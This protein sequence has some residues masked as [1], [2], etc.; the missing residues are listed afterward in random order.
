MQKNWALQAGFWITAV[1]LFLFCAYYFWQGDSDRA[2]NLFITLVG[3]ILGGFAQ[4]LFQGN[5]NQSVSFVSSSGIF[6]NKNFQKQYFTLLGYQNRD[7]DIKGLSTQTALTLE[8][9]Q[10]FVELKLQP[11]AAHKA[12][13]NP[14]NNIPGKMR[15]DS[16]PIWQFFAVLSE[17]EKRKNA[18]IVIVGPPGSGKTTLLRHITLSLVSSSQHKELKKIKFKKIPVLFYLREHVGLILEN[19]GLLLPELI[20]STITK[21]DLTVPSNWFNTRMKN[22]ECMIMLDGLDEVAEIQSRRQIVSWL[23]KQMW[24]YPNNTFMIT[25]RPHGYRENP[26]KGVSVL[27][28]MPFNRSQ[29]DNFVFNWYLANEIKSHAVDDVGVRMTAKSGASDLLTRL[30]KNAALMELAVNPLLLTMIATVHRY[31]S[32]L[33]GRRV[34]LYKEICEVFLGKRQ[35]SKGLSLDLIPAQKQS[36]LQSLAHEMMVANIREIKA[37]DA[38]EI[39]RTPLSLVKEGLTPNDF[40]RSIEQQSGLLLEREN[41]IYGFAH[42]TFQEYLASMYILEQGKEDELHRHIN[43]DWWHEVIRLYTAQTDATKIITLCLDQDPPSAMALSL[44]VQCLE[45]ARQVQPYIR[46]AAEK[47]LRETAEDPDPDIR[48]VVAEALLA[49]R[50]RHLTALSPTVA[51]DK[52]LISNAEYQLFADQMLWRGFDHYPTQWEERTYPPG[53]AHSPTAGIT[54]LNAI[55]FCTWLTELHAGSGELYFRLPVQDEIYE[56]S[57]ADV[58]DFWIA[59]DYK[60]ARLNSFIAVS[61]HSNPKFPR[62][63]VPDT[64]LRQ[65]SENDIRSIVSTLH[66]GNKNVEGIDEG[67]SDVCDSIKQMLHTISDSDQLLSNT[68]NDLYKKVTSCSLSYPVDFGYGVSG[69]DAFDQTISDSMELIKD[70]KFE[71]ATMRALAKFSEFVASTTPITNRRKSLLLA[72]IFTLLVKWIQRNNTLLMHFQTEGFDKKID[73]LIDQYW[74]CV[75]VFARQEKVVEPYE[76]LLIVREIKES[77]MRG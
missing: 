6:K 61:I 73:Y 46:D 25:S 66:T 75:T 62:P 53:T 52:K 51:I 40:L 57:Y 67:F 63:V 30:E 44:A 1:I 17:N 7:F 31:R 2:F 56:S 48:R 3:A 19:P 18:K 43:D 72:F 65:T 42:K 32:A 16:Y 50:I 24:A 13:T 77:Q 10:V 37:T 28:V 38:V 27:E 54:P 39:I 35:E 47:I 59:K 64:F 34:E 4:I 60:N 22:G 26:I 74:D 58:S 55:A 41:G 9:E 71:Q 70:R 68:A 49:N 11:Q 20:E 33:P 45:E 69:V 12:T 23:E 15:S 14:I 21:W 8:L 76:G 5:P 36:V 29:I